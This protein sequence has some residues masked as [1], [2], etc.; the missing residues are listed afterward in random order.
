VSALAA[1]VFAISLL[2]M[3]PLTG[4]EIARGLPASVRLLTRELGGRM[5][6]MGVAES[7]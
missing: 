3:P 1:P 6:G 2:G 4:K 5:P 7:A